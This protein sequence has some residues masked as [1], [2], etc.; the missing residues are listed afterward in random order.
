MTRTGTVSSVNLNI[1][2]LLSRPNFSPIQRVSSTDAGLE[3]NIRSYENAGVPLIIEDLHKGPAWPSG[4]FHIQW[5]KQ[6]ANQ[7]LSVRNV[8]D[9]TDRV[10]SL[11]EFVSRSQ[12]ANP[13]ASQE[14]TERL[15]AKDIQCPEDWRD[16]LSTGGTI[17]EMLCPEGSNDIMKYLPQSVRV[18]TLMCYLGIGDT[19]TACHKDLCASS[20]HNLMC[21]TEE[22]ASSFWFMTKSNDAPA[23]A[24]HFQHLGHEIDWESHTITLEELA[25]APFQVFVA[26]QKVGDFVL[27]PP[28]SCHQVV[29]RGGLTL[30]MS[31]SRMTVKGA[32]VALRHEL[33]IYRRVCRPEV[34]R[35]KSTIHHT[36]LHHT[37]QLEARRGAASQL[38]VPKDTDPR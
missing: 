36:L 18:E 20:G 12:A 23:V 10:I 1:D 16:W 17:P 38:G 24:R 9:G 2:E 4:M 32:A 33:P 29:N 35:I 15:Y 31:W 37:G 11:A 25:K 13:S 3:G 6:H 30:K 34:Y 8:H 21:Y 27:V 22:G 7:E 26:E 19:F 5:F 28:R 14:E